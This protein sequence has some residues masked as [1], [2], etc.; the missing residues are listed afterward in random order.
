MKK[1]KQETSSH[2]NPLKALNRVNAVYD[3]PKCNVNYCDQCSYEK[4]IDGKSVQLCLRCDSQIEKIMQKVS[5]STKV[6]LTNRYHPQPVIL[7]SK[8]ENEWRR[9]RKYLLKIK[10]G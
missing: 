7:E 8:I 10:S 1:K 6:V 3:C 2:E 5:C 4:E 9:K